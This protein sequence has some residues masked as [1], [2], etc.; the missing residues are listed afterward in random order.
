MAVLNIHRLLY[1]DPEVAWKVVVSHLLSV[2]HWAPAPPSQRV[3]AA[4][5]L[6]KILDSAS[7]TVLSADKEHQA[8]IQERLIQALKIQADDMNTVL[9]VPA[10]STDIEIRRRAYETLFKLLESNG[11]SLLCV[12]TEIFAILKAVCA[13][14]TDTTSARASTLVAASFPSIQ[15]IASDFLSNLNQNELRLCIEALAAFGRQRDDVNIALTVSR[16][17][18]TR[19]GVSS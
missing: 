3:Q 17:P 11:H 4:Q 6:D 13:K 7:S 18:L 8:E 2:Q 15:L 16:Y 10:T 9:D 19:K 5:T 14:R 1:R 12:W